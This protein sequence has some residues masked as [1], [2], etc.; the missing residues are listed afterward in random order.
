MLPDRFGAYLGLVWRGSR[1]WDT[2]TAGADQQVHTAGDTQTTG[3]GRDRSPLPSHLTLL[4]G[5]DN[6]ATAA[7]AH[8]GFSRS[9][10]PHREWTQGSRGEGLCQMLGVSERTPAPPPAVPHGPGKMFAENVPA[11]RGRHGTDGPGAPRFS[12]LKF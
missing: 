7:P 1:G 8:A 2:G 11:R 9:I 5:Q 6:A 4:Y 12:A 10:S 3:C